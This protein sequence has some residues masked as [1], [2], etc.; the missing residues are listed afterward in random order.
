MKISTATSVFLN[1]TLPDA[2]DEIVR[3]GFDGVDIWCGRPHL[4]RRDYPP[5]MLQ[6]IRQMLQKNHLTPV[7]VM[8]AFFRYPFSL[9][10][11]LD[12]IRSDSIAYMKDCID[13]AAAIGSKVV[14]VVPNHSL[15]GQ[16]LD[17]ARQ[18]FIDSLSQLAPYAARNGITLG[19]EV[20]YP[21]LSDY[22]SATDHA[23]QVIHNLGGNNLGVVL[24]SGHLNLSDEDVRSALENVGDLLLQ[25]HIND[26]DARQQQN[27][28]PGEGVFD[29]KM[30]V[31]LLRQRG[32]QGFLSLELGW[33]YT[34]DPMPAIQESLRR[35]RSLLDENQK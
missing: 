22:M 29:F 13:N 23:L 1:Y 5:E 12:A 33:G 11:P 28:I 25:M 20:V 16:T 35:V 30:L 27:A 8:P 18:R 9:S 32:Y 31:A 2:L 14:L 17:D 10:S 26:N 34:F 19:L 7:S 6:H 4:F 24:D 15:R 3:C 21:L